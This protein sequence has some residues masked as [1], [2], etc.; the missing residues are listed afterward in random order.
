MMLIKAGL[1]STAREFLRIVLG[2]YFN[3]IE[4]FQIERVPLSGPV[5]F[6]SNHP[7]SI[8]D[9]FL[10]GVT[11]P[12]PVAFVGTVQLF[13]FKPIAWLL[14]ACNIIP[15]NRVKDDPRSMRTVMET[16]EACYRV[17]EQGGAVGI[18]PEGITYNDASMRPVKSGAARM[19]LELE[20][21]HQ[22]KLGLRIVPLGLTYSGKERYRSDVLVH[23]GEPLVV[24]TFLDG[25]S[26][27]RKERIHEL[28][29]EIER[30][31]QALILHLPALERARLVRSVTRLYLDRLK[32]GG[33]IVTEA[34]TPRAEELVLTQTIAGVIDHFSRTDP[35]RVKSFVRRLA[36]YEKRLKRLGLEDPAV[37]QLSG[38]RP[39]PIAMAWQV[40][41][42]L[43]GFPVA[44]H[45]WLHRWL[46][47]LIVR[48]GVRRF[49]ARGARKAQT[50]HVSMILGLVVFGSAYVLYVTIVHATWG[51][52]ASLIYGLSL[53]VAGLYAHGYSERLRRLPLGL[54][55]L[56]IRLRAPFVAGSL[57]RQRASLIDEI[58][59][60]RQDYANSN[61]AG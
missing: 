21:R 60:A 37:G 16:F 14:R 12:R 48:R 10:V 53:P 25:Y 47:A 27:H 50:P 36:R 42:A 13:R 57:V 5:L 2:I 55:A 18:F 8:T 40:T 3:R 26:T 34:R 49:T 51:W 56:I 43:A 31:I 54:R 44:L 32:V 9:A 45:G 38:N 23:F 6:A 20:N 11:V 29:A 52:P 59:A 1:R 35:D 28:S 46:P 4:R 22:G 33:W 7:G 19:A 24:A 17:M 39:G 30:S 15:V 58:E 41:L 61:R